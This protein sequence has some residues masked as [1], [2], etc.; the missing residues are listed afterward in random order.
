MPLAANPGRGTVD[1]PTL[2]ACI[3]S[4]DWMHRSRRSRKG[5]VSGFPLLD[6]RRVSDQTKSALNFSVQDASAALPQNCQT[7]R[8]ILG[9]P[10]VAVNVT[11]VTRERC[12]FKSGCRGNQRRKSADNHIESD[13]E[14]N[15]I[16]RH[17][18]PDRFRNGLAGNSRL[19]QIRYCRCQVFPASLVVQVSR[20]AVITLPCWVSLNSTVT[21]SELRDLPSATGVIRVQCW[22]ASEEW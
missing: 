20:S 9:P 15:R 13:G 14:T 17:A 22:P 3:V 2:A 10:H 6:F 12:R 4:P 11:L 16:A 7:T 1:Q 18:G 8:W 21:I 19:D 5:G